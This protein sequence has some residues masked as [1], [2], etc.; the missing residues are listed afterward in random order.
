[1]NGPE[2]YE[3]SLDLSPED[4]ASQNQA[5]QNQGVQDQASQDRAVWAGPLISRLLDEANH[6]HWESLASALGMADGQ[7]HPRVGRL[8]QHVSVTKRGYW[9]AI[10]AAVASYQQSGPQ[11]P[12][13]HPSPDQALQPPPELDLNAV[14]LWEVQRAAALSDGQL[15]T[16]LTYS[17]KQMS[18]ADLL[19]L[20]ARHTV[21]HAGQ[22]AAL[23][24][25][26]KL[27]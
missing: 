25:G 18:V 19:R 21:W 2:S 16:V 4:R 3:F 7:P 22:I 20:N 1:M 8:V 24:S 5:S 23:S 26:P 27:A 9:E 17:G 6:A 10:A 12:Q 11:Q 13:G 14:C 15:A